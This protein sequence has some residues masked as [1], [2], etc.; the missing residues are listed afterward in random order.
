VVLVSNLCV[1]PSGNAQVNASL[2][3]PGPGTISLA[4]QFKLN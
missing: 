3:L 4:G 2:G 1:P